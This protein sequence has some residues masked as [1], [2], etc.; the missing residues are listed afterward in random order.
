MRIHF[1]A[2]GGAAMHNLAVALQEKGDIITGSDDEIK[3]PSRSRLAAHGLL[4]EKMGWFPEKLNNEIDIVILGMHAR[5]DNPELLEAKRL[6]LKICSFPE[7]LFQQTRD[8]M[9]VVI[10]GSHGKTTITAMVLHVLHKLNIP[11]DYLIGAQMEGFD[12]ML[13]LNEETRVAIFEGDEYLTSV[14]DQRPKF[15]IYQPHIAVI[16]GIEWDHIDAFPTFENYIEQFSTFSQMI[17]RNGKLIYPE[18]D[19]NIQQITENIREDITDMP[20]HT[21]EYTIESGVT[22][23]K[24]KYGDFPLQ[25]FGEHNMQNIDAARLVCRQIGVKDADF[26][27]SIATFKGLAGRMERVA[28]NTHASA[29]FDR[30]HTP[31]NVKVSIHALK[32][33]FPDRKVIACLELC[34]FSNLSSGYLPQYKKTLKEADMAFVY[35]NPNLNSYKRRSPISEEMV[36]EVF[37]EEV[38]LF[39]NNI[40]LL[41]RLS[42]ENLQDANLLFMTSGSF[43]G[44]NLVAFAQNLLKKG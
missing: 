20:Y 22:I 16:S 26:Y 1:I 14:I 25:I 34:S 28:N 6:G 23:L 13:S 38:T 39:T 21:P 33:Q 9:R 37:G 8:K 24:T 17:E 31:D 11:F 12:A 40:K 2:I 44:I 3:E 5:P 27:E 19:E 10:S 36:K 35:F 15:H 29:Y 42:E 30:A 4:P 7:Y 18:G 41:D 43:S 32:T